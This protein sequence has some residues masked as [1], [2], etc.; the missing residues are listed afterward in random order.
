VRKKGVG[1]MKGSGFA[2]VGVALGLSLVGPGMAQGAAARLGYVDVQKV[3]L[4]SAAGIA[5]RDELEKEKAGMQ[6]QVDARRDEVEKLRDEL[7]KKGLLLS[8]EAR[9]PKISRRSCSAR[10]RR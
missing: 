3:L 7:A 6:K 2:L 9:K 1:R 4:R 5:A 8:S 10:S